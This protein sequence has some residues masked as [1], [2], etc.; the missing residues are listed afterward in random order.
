MCCRCRLQFPADC[1][2]SAGLKD[3]ILRIL[4]R[5]PK[6]RLTL[7]G[8]E[9][10]APHFPHLIDLSLCHVAHLAHLSAE[11]AGWCDAQSHPW[12]VSVSEVELESERQREKEVAEEHKQ[13]ST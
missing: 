2:V 13:P 5:D 8:I 10:A 9:V 3:L 7:G 6:K 11:C 1:E 4:E 12:T